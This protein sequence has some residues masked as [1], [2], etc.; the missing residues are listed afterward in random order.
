MADKY[1]HVNRT[2]PKE[3]LIGIL[4][5]IGVVLLLFLLTIKSNAAA[6]YDAYSVQVGSK[7]TEDHPYYE[8]DY[9]NGF[10]SKGLESVIEDETLVLLYIGSP[11]CPTCVTTI[12]TI[13]SYFNSVEGINEAFDTIYYL[14]FDGPATG[15]QP[16]DDIQ[17]FLNDYPQIQ[18]TT[19]QLML[20]SNGV[21]V[22]QYFV[23]ANE[24]PERA[25]RDFFEAVLNYVE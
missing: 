3:V 6:I 7:L 9:Q 15:T 18:Q 2:I 22:L 19:P 17:A 12:G 23:D 13:E 20:I 1:Q 10:L 14:R 4:S 21:I 5:V 11:V 25:A 8:I 24:T 16:T